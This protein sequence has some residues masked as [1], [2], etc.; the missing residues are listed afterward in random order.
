M[1]KHGWPGLVFVETL[2]TEASPGRLEL[3]VAKAR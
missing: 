1:S 2:E 3:A